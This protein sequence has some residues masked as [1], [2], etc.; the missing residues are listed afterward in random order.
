MTQGQGDEAWEGEF[1]GCGDGAFSYVPD[2]EVCG[3]LV[4]EIAACKPA[5]GILDCFDGAV[6]FFTLE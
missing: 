2:A 3:D 1:E 4:H 6:R 5:K